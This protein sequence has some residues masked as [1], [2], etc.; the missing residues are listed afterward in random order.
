MGF[1]IVQ[2]LMLATVDIQGKPPLIHVGQ[3]SSPTVTPPVDASIHTFVCV[4]KMRVA[5]APVTVGQP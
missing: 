4:P 2:I 1:N 3:Y 5:L